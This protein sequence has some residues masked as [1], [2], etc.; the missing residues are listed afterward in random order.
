V[1]AS[2]LLLTV[3][4][5]VNYKSQRCSELSQNAGLLRLHFLIVMVTVIMTTIVRATCNASNATTTNPCPDAQAA[6]N[7]EELTS[8]LFVLPRTLFGRREIMENRL[9]VSLWVFVREIVILMRSVRMGWFANNA[10]ETSR[11]QDASVMQLPVKTIVELL[12]R[13]HQPRLRL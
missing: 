10:Q 12:F 5:H 13:L 8:V 6:V 3:A 7:G 2:P 1:P 4:Q 11:S 9:E